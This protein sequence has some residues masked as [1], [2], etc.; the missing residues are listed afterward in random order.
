MNNPYMHISCTH[1]KER[2]PDVQK[3][4]RRLINNGTKIFSSTRRNSSILSKA[5][6]NVHFAIKIVEIR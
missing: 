4:Y 2:V 6:P 5:Y 1:T 3:K